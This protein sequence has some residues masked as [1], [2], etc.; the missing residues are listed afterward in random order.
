VNVI[1][2]GAIETNIEENTEKQDVAEARE[3]VNYPEGRIP[4]TDGQPGTAE[5]VA[6]LVAFLASGAASHITGTEVWIDGAE[7][8]LQG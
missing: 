4:L 1:C 3:P 5:E 6:E 2:P 7:S 8:L